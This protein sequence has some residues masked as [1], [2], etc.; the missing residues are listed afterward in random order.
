MFNAIIKNGKLDLGSEYNKARFR[1]WCSEREG[2]R[3][4][5]EPVVTPRTTLQNNYYWLYL[6]IIELETG[7]NANDLHEYF[8]RKFLL[9]VF[10]SITI[11]GV[12][13]EVKIPR[14][15]TKLNKIEFG[16]YLD[17]ICA[18]TDVPLPDPIEAG[19]LPH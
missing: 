8:K 3:M 19:Y 10:I 4:K 5:I 12:K 9:P 6:S 2:K 18:E 11:K 14:T 17:K 1:Q 15:T 13:K 16:E 7:N